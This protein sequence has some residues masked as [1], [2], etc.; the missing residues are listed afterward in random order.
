MLNEVCKNMYILQV[1][2]IFPHKFAKKAVLLQRTNA[3]T[4]I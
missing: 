3:R 4:F 2:S 1:P